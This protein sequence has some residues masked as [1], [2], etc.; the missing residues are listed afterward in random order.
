MLLFKPGPRRFFSDRTSFSSASEPARRDTVGAVAKP[1]QRRSPKHRNFV[2]RE[3]SMGCS[4]RPEIA[5]RSGADIADT[6][7]EKAPFFFRRRI[8]T[9]RVPRDDEQSRCWRCV[10]SRTRLMAALAPCLVAESNSSRAYRLSASRLEVLLEDLLASSPRQAALEP[11]SAAGQ[12]I[13]QR[14]YDADDVAS[15]RDDFAEVIG[16]IWPIF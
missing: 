15:S 7:P 2:R 11:I 3:G 5:T 16:V 12:C 9:E 6:C 1:R 13:A 10:C 4:C 8:Q 14:A